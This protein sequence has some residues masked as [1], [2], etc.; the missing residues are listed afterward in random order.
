MKK[1]KESYSVKPVRD[2]NIELLRIVAMFL[3]LLDHSGYTSINPPTNEEVFSTPMLSLARHCC[4]SFSSICVNVFV[5]ISGWFGIKA[6]ISRIVEFLFQCYFICFVSYFALLAIGIASPMSMGDWVCFFVLGDLWF[7]MAYLILYLM[8]PM[9]NMFIESL[10]QKQFLYFLLAFLMIQFLHGFVIQVSWFDKGMSPF[11][12]MSLYMVG[13]YMRLFPNR[14]I[15]MNKWIDMLIYFVVSF[16]GAV[17]TFAGVRHGAEGYRFFSYA[18]P[19]I[20]IASV[21]FFLFF[22]KF[23]FKSRLVNWVAASAFAVYVLDC[24]GHFWSFYLSTNHSW[25]MSGSPSAYL[26]KTLLFDVAVFIVAIFLDKIRIIVWQQV[27]RI[28]P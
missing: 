18:S 21:Y 6:K 16:L 20:I 3:V 25:W 22:T 1:E 23:S 13:R 17:F 19:T 12:L 11:T 8:A 28:M 14:Y 15:T 5:L 24:E 7:V 10:T 26:I 9:I 4:Q 2:S 27:K